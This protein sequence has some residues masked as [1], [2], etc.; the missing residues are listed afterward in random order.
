M[1]ISMKVNCRKTSEAYKYH[2]KESVL[3]FLLKISIAQFI[4]N[5]LSMN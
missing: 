2:K 4:L 5:A 1:I 3:L